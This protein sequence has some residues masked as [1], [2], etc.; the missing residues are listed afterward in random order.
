MQDE[1][2]LRVGPEAQHLTGFIGC[3]RGFKI[4]NT[5]YDLQ[6]NA[7]NP[8]GKGNRRDEIVVGLTTFEGTNPKRN[9]LADIVAPAGAIPGCRMKCDDEPCKHQGICI[10]DFAK[11]ESSCNCEHT[12]YYGEFCGQGA[13]GGAR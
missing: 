2:L 3:I 10:E 7:T 4:G 5:V 6:A 1:T 9:A 11:G 12:S 8:I 13:Y